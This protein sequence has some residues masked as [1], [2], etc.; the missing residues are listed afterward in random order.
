[1]KAKLMVLLLS[2]FCLSAVA[3]ESKTQ[4]VV[5]A[6]DGSKTVFPLS[7]S[8]KITFSETDLTVMVNSLETVFSLSDVEQFT[9]D[10]SDDIR[11]TVVLNNPMATFCSPLDLDF[12]SVEGVKAYVANSFDP[13]TGVL[14]MR[15]VNHVPAGAGIVLIGQMGTYEVPISN[16]HPIYDNLLKG[17]TIATE[18]VPEDE[19]YVNYI[20]VN[21]SNGTGFYRLSSS[22]LLSAGKSYL[23]LPKTVAHSR[24]ITI[25][26]DGI[27][28]DFYP[29]EVSEFDSP[30]YRLDGIRAMTPL[31]KGI[32]MQN[33]KKI[34]VK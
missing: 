23:Q 14:S 18:I 32:Y 34:I 19:D 25:C 2:F 17:V 27:T 3:D 22:G 20:L 1:M 7:C 15:S 30:Y 4:L 13:E 6:K 9:Y 11:C 33:G 8:P 16:E 26:Y 29:F 21:G 10:A 12:T 31:R 5:W 28:T 24:N